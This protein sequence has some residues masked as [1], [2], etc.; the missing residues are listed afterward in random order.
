MGIDNSASHHRLV[1]R[2]QGRD[3]WEEGQVGLLKTSNQNDQASYPSS[4]RG[5]FPE[6]I[7]RPVSKK[8]GETW[9]YTQIW[10]NSE[11]SVPYLQLKP[12][13]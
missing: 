6:A 8:V 12:K 11:P 13:N 3:R 4:A 2:L 9:I 5:H 7:R 1:P 10:D